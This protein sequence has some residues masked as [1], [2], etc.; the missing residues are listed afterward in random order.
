MGGHRGQSVGHGSSLCLYPYGLRLGDSSKRPVRVAIHH[1]DPTLPGSRAR[2]CTAAAYQLTS[3]RFLAGRRLSRRAPGD[4]ARTTSLKHHQ[5][6]IQD[7]GCGRDV[8][9]A[10]P[11][12]QGCDPPPP[13]HRIPKQDD[14]CRLTRLQT[15]SLCRRQ[16]PR[17]RPRSSSCSTPSATSSPSTSRRRP[18]HPRPSRGTPRP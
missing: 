7:V 1:I 8:P 3:A 6:N 2:G 14:V 12:A 17:G 16:S 4:L 11:L 10:Q 18:G 9:Q 15:T 5:G 13:P